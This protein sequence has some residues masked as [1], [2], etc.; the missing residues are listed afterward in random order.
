MSPRVHP[1]TKYPDL[2]KFV[3]RYC[4]PWHL[5]PRA[6]YE[7]MVRHITKIADKQPMTEIAGVAR[8]LIYGSS[9]KTSRPDNPQE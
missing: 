7:Q 2:V 4:N 9:L 3:K 8:I 1:R 6:D 5:P